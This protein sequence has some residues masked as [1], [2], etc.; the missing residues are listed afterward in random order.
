MYRV[1]KRNQNV[2]DFERSKIQNAI[3]QAFEAT[4]IEYAQD[5]IDLIALK[6]TADF[7][8]KIVDGLVS[9]EDIQDSVEAVLSSA[10]Y[11]EVAKAYTLYRRQRQKL[12]EVK[13]TL[14]D[15]K[16]IVDQYVN[17]TDWREK[18]N[19]PGTYSVGGLNPA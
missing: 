9:V 8:P 7:Q 4:E 19:S 13:S 12:R 2:V 6:V 10:G 5:V 14:L 3:I 17:V 16:E 1:V 18:E 15:Y 11:A